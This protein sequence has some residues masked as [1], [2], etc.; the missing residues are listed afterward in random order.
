M[1]PGDLVAFRRGINPFTKNINWV[2]GLILEVIEDHD[3][4]EDHC[5][6]LTKH[7]IMY[8]RIH[9]SQNITE[10]VET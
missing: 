2:L 1:K 10:K 8:F 5:K 3:P 6:T 7:G 4:V 9:G